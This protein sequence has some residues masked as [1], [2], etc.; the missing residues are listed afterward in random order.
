MRIAAFDVETIP[1]TAYVWRTGQQFVSLDQVVDH[2]RMVC[3]AVRFNDRKKTEFYSEWEHG[4]QGLAEQARRV[5]DEADAVLHFNGKSFDEKW[6]RSVIIQAGLTPP[7]PFKS[8]DLYQQT[9]QFYLMSHKLQ[10]VS[11]TLLKLE[12]KLDTGGFKLWRQVMAGDE[13][14]RRLFKRYNIQDV[15][16]LWEAFEV[17][18]PWLKLPNANLY[19]GT[20]DACPTCGK[21]DTL[22]RRGF[23][24]LTTGVYQQYRCVPE[25]GGCGSW[26]RGT[27][28]VQ[29]ATVTA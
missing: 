17:L 25:R 6:M 11:T 9:K 8:I 5:L 14:A 10:N 21:S 23:K 20:E 16:L 18:K 13:K 7:S 2:S 1:G 4:Q 19:Q 3:F 26:T 15:D 24:A 12:G 29:A 27:S 22:E 28:R